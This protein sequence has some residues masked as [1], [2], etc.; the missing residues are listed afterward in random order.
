MSTRASFTSIP[1][2][3]QQAAWESLWTELLTLADDT[4]PVEE[5]RRD[6]IGEK[7]IP[8]RREADEAA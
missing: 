7:R 8:L 5:A 6:E 4:P 2:E 3:V 1:A